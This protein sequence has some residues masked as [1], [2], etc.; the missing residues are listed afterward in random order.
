MDDIPFFVKIDHL[1]IAVPSLEAAVPTW[2][3][4]FGKGPEHFEEVPDQRVRTAFFGVG[5]SHFELLEP[6]SPDSPIA[7]FLD[8]RRGGTDPWTHR[9][10]GAGRR[11]RRP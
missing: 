3:T 6:T 11:W 9:G 7:A 2:T 1:G 8:K 4:L 10:R 5:E